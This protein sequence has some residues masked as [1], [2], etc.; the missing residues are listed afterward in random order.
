MSRLRKITN[1]P[2]EVFIG[3]VVLIS[4][5]YVASLPVNSLLNWF[6]TDDAFY[7]YKTAANIAHGFGSTFDRI[8]QT[9]GYHPLWMVICIPIFSLSKLNLILPLRLIVIVQGIL[10]I[11]TGILLFRTLKRALSN[12]L[13]ASLTFFWVL[14]P[15]I[16]NI[17]MVGGL[18]TGINA[19][20]LILLLNRMVI[21]EEKQEL[22]D[23]FLKEAFI[24]GII[25]S[26]TILSRLD[27]IFLVG[28]IS[29]WILWKVWGTISKNNAI[30]K[31]RSSFIK[32]VLSYSVP[33]II[34]MGFYISWNI[35]YFGHPMPISGKVKIWWGVLE[36]TV[37]G[38]KPPKSWY[39]K[40]HLIFLEPNGPWGFFVKAKEWFYLVLKSIH[41][42]W[43]SRL[44]WIIVM[45]VGLVTLLWKHIGKRIKA[46]VFIPFLIGVLLHSGYYPIVE[47]VGYRDWYWISEMLIAL[48]FIGI[49]LDSLYVKVFPSELQSKNLILFSILS[50]PLISIITYQHFNH[51][52]SRYP[53]F[54]QSEEQPHFYLDR[55]RWL[56]ENTQDDA[57]IGAAGSGALGYFIS[58]RTIIPLDGLINSFEYFESIKQGEGVDYL[59]EIGMDY[60]FGASWIKKASPYAEIFAENLKTVETYQYSPGWSENY[61]YRFDVSLS[62]SGKQ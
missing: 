18:E 55:A 20:F 60:V 48:I 19:F 59:S 33:L 47:Y 8:G 22:N 12:W 52:T 38:I 6:H 58:D 35:I 62:T 61:L 57:R 1:Y 10:N 28:I 26:F 39:K 46:V 30:K 42:G 21:L 41:L 17:T 32:F 2:V 31:P 56:T 34:L 36:N 7:Y 53:L 29:I 16:Y 50:V 54:R 37:Y 51:L 14:M 44:R 40:M 49:L 43:L 15:L 3:I 23:N 9:N 4:H 5:V 11:A 27:N 25:S 45:G 24:L 13:A